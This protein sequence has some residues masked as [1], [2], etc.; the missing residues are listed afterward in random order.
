MLPGHGAAGE[1]WFCGSVFGKGIEISN[2]HEAYG[3]RGSPGCF[4]PPKWERSHLLIFSGGSQEG[5]HFL[6]SEQVSSEGI[7]ALS[8]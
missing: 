8:P 7:C 6:Q 2:S 1:R 3:K 5:N 4:K